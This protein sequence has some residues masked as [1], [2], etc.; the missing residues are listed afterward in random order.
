MYL[1]VCSRPQ[2]V[3]TLINRRK[4]TK[5][6]HKQTWSCYNDKAT[7]FFDLAEIESLYQHRI[8]FHAHQKKP[9][10]KTKKN[11]PQTPK[12][13]ATLEKC[14]ELTDFS[15]SLDSCLV[16]PSVFKQNCF[17]LLCNMY[18]DKQTVGSFK[19]API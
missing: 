17:K 13:I 11:P 9:N 10:Q 4:K 12:K 7:D 1:S 5:D 2:F 6:N 19:L 8:V 16:I 18:K 15:S 14:P 3:I